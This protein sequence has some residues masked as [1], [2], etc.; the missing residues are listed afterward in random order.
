MEYKRTKFS[1]EYLRKQKI[2]F[3]CLELPYL[4]TKSNMRHIIGMFKVSLVII[5]KCFCYNLQDFM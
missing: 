3:D 5:L 1:L 4:R 2:E